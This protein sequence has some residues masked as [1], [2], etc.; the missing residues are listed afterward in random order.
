VVGLSAQNWK[1]LLEMKFV[2]E[3][4]VLKA[5]IRRIGIVNRQNRW[6]GAPLSWPLWILRQHRDWKGP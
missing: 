4:T 2:V 5:N 6:I 3:M 1:N